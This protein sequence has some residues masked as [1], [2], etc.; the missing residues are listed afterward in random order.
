MISQVQL[1]DIAAWVNRH[2]SGEGGLAELRRQHPNI[3]FTW[4]M[5]DDVDY[6]T[7]AL[8]GKG[9][10]L[11]LV[12]GREHCLRFTDAYDAATGVVIAEITED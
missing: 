4:C 9:F 6:E 5:D 10:N 2:G 3:H 7:P 12:D 1:A 11:Y 8:A